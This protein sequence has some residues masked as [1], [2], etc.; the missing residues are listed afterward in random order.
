[1]PFTHVLDAER[2]RVNRQAVDGDVADGET[3]RRG[4]LVDRAQPVQP[5]HA[6]GTQEIL[7]AYAEALWSRPS[8]DLETDRVSEEKSRE[9]RRWIGS[10]RQ[11]CENLG[12]FIRKVFATVSPGTRYIPNWHIDAIVG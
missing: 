12:S 4:H 6:G 8:S 5:G 2:Q 10:C 7:D 3:L 1:M 9:R 11:S